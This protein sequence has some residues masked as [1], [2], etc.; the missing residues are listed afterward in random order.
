MDG[1]RVF[2]RAR[3]TSPARQPA[4]AAGLLQVS[5]QVHD[6]L[7]SLVPDCPVERTSYDDCYMDVTAACAAGVASGPQR[8]QQQP[9]QGPST[10]REVPPPAGLLW[11]SCSAALGSQQ[12]G[13]LPPN[14]QAPQP[15]AVND[16]GGR[17]AVLAPDMQRGV[18]LAAA[19]RAA[20]KER[21]RLTISC[22]V[23]RS[24]LVA[25]LASPLGKPGGRL[26]TQRGVGHG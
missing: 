15:A 17:W 2:T 5:Q 7:R 26:C 18:Q 3:P 16:P 23:A 14:L 1:A 25:R 22:G 20:A 19:L 8:R 4:S 21:L 24:R 13:Q 11:V 9:Q 12:G 6:L 10:G